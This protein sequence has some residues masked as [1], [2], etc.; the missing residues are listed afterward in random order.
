MS[1]KPAIQ[2]QLNHPD[3]HPELDEL[4]L[5][6]NSVCSVPQNAHSQLSNEQQILEII[7]LTLQSLDTSIRRANNRTQSTPSYTRQTSKSYLPLLARKFYFCFLATFAI[8]QDI[9]GQFVFGTTLFSFIP[10]INVATIM[11]ASFF[12]VGLNAILLYKF[13]ISNIKETLNIPYSTTTVEE[14]IATYRKQIKLISSIIKHLSKL[15]SLKLTSEAY[16]AY[17][18][19]AQTLDQ[20][21]RSKLTG[22]VQHQPSILKKSLKFFILTVGVISNTASSYFW[23][24]E[25]L[26]TF[27]YSL[28]GTPLGWCI[29]GLSILAG[30]GYYYL[31]DGIN[32]ARFVSPGYDEFKLMTREFNCFKKDDGNDLNKIFLLKNQFDEIVSQ[33]RET[34]EIKVT[35][36]FATQTDFSFLMLF[37]GSKQH[38]DVPQPQQTERPTP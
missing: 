6:F 30:V 3:S 10:G 27:A 5:A 24:H 26:A 36:T 8:L 20:R 29:I 13:E 7:R 32:I 35:R 1:P 34:K 16:K 15:E 14:L 38:T 28:V 17:W 4:I 11:V 9:S 22:I 2:C 19:F 33:S 18:T 31:K 25:I 12:Y 37:T 21:L 23:T